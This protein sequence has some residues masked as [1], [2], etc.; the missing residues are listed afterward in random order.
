MGSHGSTVA[1]AQVHGLEGIHPLATLGIVS[2]SHVGRLVT[3]S[4]TD[5]ERVAGS[6][7]VQ[8]V[9]LE[10]VKQGRG[11]LELLKALGDLGVSSRRLMEIRAGTEGLE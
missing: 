7:M 11:G 1:R 5:S 4:R 6:T 10:T 8:V 3:E 2:T 9:R